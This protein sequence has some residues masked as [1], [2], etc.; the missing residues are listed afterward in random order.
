MRNH[1][2]RSGFDWGQLF[3]FV[4][5]VAIGFVVGVVVLLDAVIP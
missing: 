1:E 4:L 3:G 2:W 5:G